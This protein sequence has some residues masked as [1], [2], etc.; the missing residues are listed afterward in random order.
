[1]TTTESVDQQAVIDH[2]YWHT[3]QPVRSIAEEVGR[4]PQQITDSVTP[5]PAGVE[6]WWCGQAVAFRRRRDR[7]DAQRRQPLTRCHCGALQP[8]QEFDP[9]LVDSA[10]TILV[11][12]AATILVDSAATILVATTPGP[13]M[14]AVSDTIHRGIDALARC[15]LRWTRRYLAVDFGAGPD[16][17]MR[18]LSVL[19]ERT[20]VVPT[21]RHLG[22]NDGDSCVLLG[23]LVAAGWRVITTGTTRQGGPFYEA[24]SY[25]GSPWD[26]L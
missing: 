25:G 22:T 13:S 19:P 8:S 26:L 10:A 23:R 6:C 2:R 5:L 15:G 24:C 21:L 11:D 4:T 20:I 1:M 7:A 17:V 12:S 3:S 18:A 9:T 14:R 16:A